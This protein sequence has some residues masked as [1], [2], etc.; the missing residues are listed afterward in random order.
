M[1]SIICSIALIA[2]VGCAEVYKPTSNNPALLRMPASGSF[3]VGDQISLAAIDGVSVDAPTAQGDYWRIDP[4][5]RQLKITYEAS[6]RI[7]GPR[8]AAPPLILNAKLEQGRKYEVILESSTIGVKAFVRQE[9]N[10]H[11]VSNIAETALVTTPAT[12]PSPPPFW[13]IPVRHH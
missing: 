7:V 2:I 9:A 10:K 8:V 3:G 12:Y 4:G 13:Q 6:N 11:V 1:R 5:M